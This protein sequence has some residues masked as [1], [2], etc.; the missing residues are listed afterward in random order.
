MIVLVSIDHYTFN[1]LSLRELC[2][3]LPPC[4]IAAASAHETITSRILHKKGKLIHTIIL[5]INNI[6]NNINGSKKTPEDS[7]LEP[8]FDI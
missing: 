4:L 2:T 5:P 7:E 1:I 6:N 3:Y 8:D